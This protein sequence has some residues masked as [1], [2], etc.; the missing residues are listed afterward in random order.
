M[1]AN[2]N[3]PTL[4]HGGL[5]AIRLRRHRILQLQRHCGALKL[6]LGIVS[7]WCAL[8]SS[9]LEPQVA[10][11]RLWRVPPNR[12]RRGNYIYT[13]RSRRNP[14]TLASNVAVARAS[15]EIFELVF[16][17]AQPVPKLG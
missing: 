5:R 6:Q 10:A 9:R 12:R 1:E 13:H 16:F 7:M 2:R 15:G 17:G 11:L 8:P 3:P 14:P 4:P